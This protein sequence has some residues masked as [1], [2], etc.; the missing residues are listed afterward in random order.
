M[1]ELKALGRDKRLGIIDNLAWHDPSQKTHVENMRADA[2]VARRFILGDEASLEVG[3]W[4][5]AC[6][7]LLLDNLQFAKPPF[8]VTYV[9]LSIREMHRGLM[10]PVTGPE[11]DADDRL[12]FLIRDN[13]VRTLCSAPNYKTAAGCWEYWMNT[14][15]NDI[16]LTTD[17]VE[18]NEW[19]RTA[20]LLGSTVEALRDEAQRLA[21]IYGTR[22]RCHMPRSEREIRRWGPNK[23]IKNIEK[24]VQGAAGEMRTLWAVLL[25]IN[26]HHHRL[27]FTHVPRHVSFVPQ[28]K[29]FQAHTLVTIPITPEA[30]I[31]H[32]YYPNTRASPVGHEVRGHWMHLH[33]HKGC[34]HDWPTIPDNQGHFVCASCRGWRTWRKPH[35]RGDASKG[36]NL[37]T[38][39]VT[40]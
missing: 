2:R 14:P 16:H 21:L 9:E 7:D 17:T 31:R 28:R 34:V 35:H 1:S 11:K 6:E 23:L 19:V 24:L 36:I 4:T 15:E 12:A 5:R 3:K 8:P 38:Y 29:V 20:L 13:H 10:R 32:T 25:L 37:H 22:I 40:P 27:N 26:Q 30:A 18:R 33:L 39:E